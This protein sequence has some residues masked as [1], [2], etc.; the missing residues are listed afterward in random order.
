MQIKRKHAVG[1]IA[2]LLWLSFLSIVTSRVPAVQDLVAMFNVTHSCMG[3]SESGSSSFCHSVSWQKARMFIY[4]PHEELP[5]YYTSSPLTDDEQDEFAKTLYSTIIGNRSISKQ[6]SSVLKDFTCFTVFPEC[7]V[8]GNAMYFPPCKSLCDSVVSQCRHEMKLDLK[9]GE[10]SVTA[11][12]TRRPSLP[13]DSQYLPESQGPYTLLPCVYAMMTIINAFILLCT[14]WLYLW[15]CGLNQREAH[16]RVLLVFIMAIRVFVMSICYLFWTVTVENNNVYN[17]FDTDRISMLHHMCETC[18]YLGFLLYYVLLSTEVVHTCFSLNYNDLSN[19]LSL[20]FHSTAVGLFVLMS[21]SRGHNYTHVLKWKERQAQAMIVMTIYV[22]FAA[23]GSTKATLD[24]FNTWL[25]MIIPIYS[26]IFL[27]LTRYCAREV[28]IIN[29]QIEKLHRGTENENLVKALL[30]KRL[31]FSQ[32]YAVIW[33][34]VITETICLILFALRVQ[35]V[36]LMSIVESSSTI[37]WAC[38]VYIFA[39]RHER[40]I[41]FYMI[42]SSHVGSDVNADREEDINHQQATPDRYVAALPLINRCSL[43]LDLRIFFACD[44]LCPVRSLSKLKMERT[45]IRMMR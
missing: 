31:M 37:I 2:I 34:Y 17:T 22:I 6:C 44:V 32:L 25:T 5:P 29:A 15:S 24:H 40:S 43:L 10:Y 30:D 42:P 9:C 4:V 3:S 27:L 45:L 35:W 36:A 28:A 19:I 39:C 26:V 1:S 8:T 14:I 12:M 21:L 16:L 20:S 23:F 11:C 41:F 7:P 13:S 33:V 38:I 18:K